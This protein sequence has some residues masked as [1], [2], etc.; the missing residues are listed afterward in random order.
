MLK[1]IFLK[2]AVST[3]EHFRYWN[4]CLFENVYPESI[5]FITFHKCA[6]TLFSGYILR[7]VEGLLHIDYA[8]LIYEGKITNPNKIVF[9]KRGYIYGPLRLTTHPESNV[10]KM[11]VEPICKN[12]FLKDKIAIFLIRDPRDILVSSYYS[13]GFTHKL[14]KIKET[15][16]RQ[17]ALRK[18]IQSISVDEYVLEHSS[19]INK[20]FKELFDLSKL[21]QRSVVLKYEDLINDFDKFIK[22]FN[23]YVTLNKKVIEEIYRRSRPK[24]KEDLSSHRRSGRINNYKEKL[25]EKTIAL[26]NIKLKEVLQRFEYEL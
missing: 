9:K 20:N 24:E 7:K 16:E 5:Y 3:K 14:S 12:D 10:H 8:K 6:S 23:T 1:K 17:E 11:L 15:R 25:E 26:L 2:M 13:Y 19:N 21:C 22:N 18:K 4:R